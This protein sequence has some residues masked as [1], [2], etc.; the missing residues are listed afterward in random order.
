MTDRILIRDLA[1]R[2]VIGVYP[3]ER[4]APQDVLINIA[5][6]TDVRA[7]ARSDALNDAV[8]YKAL[9]K[10][11]VALVEQSSFRLLE[12]LADRI[13]AL[14]TS[15]RGVRRATVTVDKPGALRFARSVAVEVV[16]SRRPT[17]RTSRPE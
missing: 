3:E 6:E 9:K 14:C 11:I 15:R 5:L 8:D 1:L 7:A 4:R 10:D 16:R 12:T 13:A 17:R 2:C